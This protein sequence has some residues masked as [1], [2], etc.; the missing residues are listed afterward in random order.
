MANNE[1]HPVTFKRVL[2]HIDGMDSVDVR[3]DISY[4]EAGADALA[5]D[6][7]R[8]VLP[9][10][11][12]PVVVL[13]T[14]YPDVGVPR[15]LGCA[16]KEMAM[17]TSLGQLLAASGLAVVGYTAARPAEDL[18]RLLA[19]LAAHARTLAV[20]ATRIG[21]W[22]TSGHGPTALGALARHRGGPLKAAVLS[23]GF[24][25]DLAGSMV[26]E[27][28]RAYGFAMTGVSL[29][30]L[31][32]DVPMFIARGGRDEIPGLNAT[33]D[34]FAAAALARNW[35]V[36]IVNHATGGHAFEVND[37]G[38]AARYVIREMLSFVR[39]WLDVERT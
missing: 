28:S 21:L 13:V 15:R 19:H 29:D 6:I 23:T 4:V 12:P 17:W 1:R 18:D 32:V 33:L 16:F 3:R 25:L 36:T 2:Y 20:D 38:A 22:A 7:Y 26:A 31:P 10:A 11:P 5:F 35:P 8:P 27:A 30:D 39:F 9:A 37:E 14:G 34:R 24:T